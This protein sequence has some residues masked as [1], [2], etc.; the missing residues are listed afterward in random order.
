[1]RIGIHAGSSN[2]DQIA[3]Q[4][5]Q[6]GVDE[7][8]LG[9][10]AIPE[11][12]ERGYITSD[13]VR[14]FRNTLAEHG[15]RVSGMIAPVP[16]KE[17]VLGDN[18]AEV[19]NLCKTLRAMGEAGIE[20][21]LF[22]ALDRFIYFHEYHPGKPMEV[23]PGE[24][25]WDEI[26]QFF[27]RVVSVADEVNLKLANHLWAVDMMYAICDA[28]DSPNNGVTY[29]QG[30]YIFGE[31]PHTA[32]EKWGIDRI[33]FCHARNLVRHGPSFQEYEE[34]PLDSGDVD[35]ARCVRAL[36]EAGYDGV[37]VPEHLG[38]GESISDAVAYLKK[39]IDGE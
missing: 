29:C 8:F 31:D 3:V 32:V 21:T 37:I 10:R 36:A 33:F 5:R 2:A 4:C 26:I 19:A 1:V 38:K 23:M 22:Y 6:A 24:E 18:E 34:V 20:A 17:A 16:S 12:A 27:R 35:I 39:L 11:F 15:V 13:S 9:A 7:V 14:A 30:M 28:V 25:G